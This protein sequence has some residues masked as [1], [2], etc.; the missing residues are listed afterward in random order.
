MAYSYSSTGSSGAFF[1]LHCQ[2]VPRPAEPSRVVALTI[3]HCMRKVSGAEIL[4][5][6]MSEENGA[7]LKQSVVNS[8]LC[9]ALQSSSARQLA[10]D[11]GSVAVI[12]I[13]PGFTQVLSVK[14]NVAHRTLNIVAETLNIVQYC[15]VHS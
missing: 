5:S 15:W 9:S 14:Y 6:H 2:Q 13:V 3:L 4:M 12:E 7:N 1:F 11:C 10:G 8:N